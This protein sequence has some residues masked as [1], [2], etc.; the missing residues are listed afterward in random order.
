MFFNIP[1]SDYYKIGLLIRVPAAF[2]S[3]S[4]GYS[5]LESKAT[6]PRPQIS[7]SSFGDPQPAPSTSSRH[8][9]CDRATYDQRP[10]EHSHFF[11]YYV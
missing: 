1:S 5:T 6:M 2:Q 11:L 8:L 7:Y 4:I 9:L 3:L 10:H